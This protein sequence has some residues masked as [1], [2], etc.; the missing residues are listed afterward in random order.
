MGT[1]RVDYEQPDDGIVILAADALAPVPHPRSGLSRILCDHAD[2][3]LGSARVASD[4]RMMLRAVLVAT[5]A[6]GRP[7]LA[8]V[9]AWLGIG[10]RALQ[11]RL[12]EAGTSWRAEVDAVRAEQARLLDLGLSQR[13]WQL[14]W[15]TAASGAC[16]GLSNGGRPRGRSRVHDLRALI[17]NGV[18]PRGL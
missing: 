18:R 15:V 5:I 17:P 9:S 6:Q 2:L 13:W 11:R 16:A 10:P 1:S 12:D 14:G 8:A 4:W 3:L 7:T